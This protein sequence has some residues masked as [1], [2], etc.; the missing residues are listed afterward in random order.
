MIPGYMSDPEKLDYTYTVGFKDAKTLEVTINFK[1]P[2][3][4]SANQPEDILEITFWGP[5]YD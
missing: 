1:T 5:F 3:Y 4:V 2:T